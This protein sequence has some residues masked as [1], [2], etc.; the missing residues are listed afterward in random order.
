MLCK[1]SRDKFRY[2]VL[3]PFLDE[4]F[5]PKDNLEAFTKF[6]YT[7]FDDVTVVDINEAAQYLVMNSLNVLDVLYPQ[8]ENYSRTILL[9]Y[10]LRDMG[11]NPDFGFSMYAKDC[12]VKNGEMKIL[13]LPEDVE[14]TGMVIGQD[15][16]VEEK[17]Y[18]L[19]DS[20]PI[21]AYEYFLKEHKNGK[22]DAY[23]VDENKDLIKLG[24]QIN[25]EGY[26][27]MTEPEK[28][29]GVIQN[30]SENSEKTYSMF[31]RLNEYYKRLKIEKHR[32]GLD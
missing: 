7:C 18:L 19:M 26:Y 10:I 6:L 15:T 20:K 4:I 25:I 21:K 1:L 14:I 30:V 3:L 2:K 22:Q 13:E 27:L 23:L 9:N 32:S 17:R 24:K 28:Y 11:E 31:L 12:S 5:K 29:N 16:K 8:K